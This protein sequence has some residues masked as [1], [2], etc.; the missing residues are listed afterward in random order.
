LQPAQSPR[1]CCRKPQQSGSRWSSGSLS[2]F[3]TTSSK[4]LVRHRMIVRPSSVSSIRH[5]V[6]MK[7][8]SLESTI[9]ALGTL[10]GNGRST[11][12][13]VAIIMST[14]ARRTNICCV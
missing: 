1:Y 7:Q 4:S 2:S 13:S 11:L 5:S 6:E 10:T 9:T 8:D 14:Y 3:D 12:R